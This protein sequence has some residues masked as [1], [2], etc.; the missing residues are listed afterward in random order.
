MVFPAFRAPC[1][2]NLGCQGRHSMRNRGKHK[3]IGLMHTGTTKHFF[4][5]V[6]WT[7][8][9]RHQTDCG[10]LAVWVFQIFLMPNSHMPIPNPCFEQLRKC[11]R[12]SKRT[13]SM[14]SHVFPWFP[15]FIWWGSCVF[16]YFW[17][18]GY[19]SIPFKKMTVG[20]GRW[21]KQGRQ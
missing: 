18:G 21:S 11:P 5:N 13:R 1:A 9:Q 14:I 2:K 3:K 6:T 12:S 20:I 4:L 19:S 8:E 10:S 17:G 7:G 15:T 16:V